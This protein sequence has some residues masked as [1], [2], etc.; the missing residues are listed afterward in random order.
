V[1]VVF[2]VACVDE[3]S[4]CVRLVA[5]VRDEPDDRQLSTLNF[6]P[7]S[8]KKT[9]HETCRMFCPTGCWSPRVS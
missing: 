3:V 8:E 1:K 4:G 2:M 9:F 5:A 6:A 7:A